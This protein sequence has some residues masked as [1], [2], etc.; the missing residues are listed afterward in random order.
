[1]EIRLEDEIRKEKF[2]PLG[3]VRINLLFDFKQ[4]FLYF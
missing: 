3:Q 2:Q 1:M 4:N